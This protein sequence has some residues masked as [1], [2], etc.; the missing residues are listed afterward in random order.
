MAYLLLATGV[1]LAVTD[2]TRSVSA[3][4]LM[5][6][7]L[8]DALR[9]AGFAPPAQGAAQSLAQTPLAPLAAVLFVAIYGWTARRRTPRHF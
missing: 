4:V 2:A 8:A 5:M 7:Q 6:T 1:V 3:G 9:A